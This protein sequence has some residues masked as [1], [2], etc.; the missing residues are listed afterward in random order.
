MTPRREFILSLGAAY[1]G[2]GRLRAVETGRPSRTA[3]LVAVHRA[4]AAGNPD[5]ATQNPDFLARRL[6]VQEDRELI[7]GGFGYDAF[8]M[9]WS[10]VREYFRKTFPGAL[11]EP[12]P[13][14]QMTLR[15]RH[16]DSAV[17]AALGDGTEQIVI[18]GSGLDSRPYRLTSDWTRGRV[19]EVD[20]PPSLELKKSRVRS[21][22][23][24]PPKNLT[25][26]P[27]DFTKETLEQVLQRG[28]YRPDAKTLFVWEGVTMYLPKEAVEATLAFVAKGSG[29]G[30][31]I[32]FDYYDEAIPTGAH[33]AKIWHAIAERFATWGEPFIF[34]VPTEP[35]GDIWQVVS[36]QGLRLTGDWTMGELGRI[37]FPSDFQPATLGLGRWA[38]RLCRAE[39]S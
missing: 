28:G 2:S 1:V 39:R 4:V 18:L 23:G 33:G 24:E 13:F 26:L 31:A 14:A 32:V 6:L 35:P 7:R 21:A 22:L 12:L 38:W 17:N 8:A 16:L 10:E 11:F 3:I 27:I 36:S 29:A 25:Y 5:P 15:T 34:G 37:H 30:S 19:F 20:F 9:T